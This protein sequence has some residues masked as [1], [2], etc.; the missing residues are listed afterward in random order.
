MLGSGPNALPS[1]SNRPAPLNHGRAWRAHGRAHGHHCS[2]PPPHEQILLP[3]LCILMASPEGLMGMRPSAM[4]PG[5][6][7][8][9]W[10]GRRQRPAMWPLTPS[11]HR[12]WTTTDHTPHTALRSGQKGLGCAL[13]QTHAATKRVD[14]QT[15]TGRGNTLKAVTRRRGSRTL[16]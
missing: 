11:Q 15:C 4:S 8:Y 3:K 1:Y 16:F 9:G 13:T 6:P 2:T 14:W 7:E 5:S 10:R 12:G